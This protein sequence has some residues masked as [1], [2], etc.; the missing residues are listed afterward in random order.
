[1]NFPGKA[2]GNWEWRFSWTQVKPEHAQVLEDFSKEYGRLQMV[3][4]KD[5]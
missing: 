3:D 4:K 2:T 1:M 5:Q